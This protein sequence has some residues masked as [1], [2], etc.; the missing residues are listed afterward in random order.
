[1]R[2]LNGRKPNIVLPQEQQA[3]EDENCIHYRDDPSLNKCAIALMDLIT[4]RTAQNQYTTNQVIDE[5]IT[6]HGGGAK[7]TAKKLLEATGYITFDLLQRKVKGWRA[8][9]SCRNLS[10]IPS[11]AVRSPYYHLPGASSYG[12]Y[13]YVF[14]RI[15]DGIYKIGIT[16]NLRTRAP[17]IAAACG[18]HIELYIA[19]QMNDYQQIEVE[20]HE[21]FDHKRTVGEWFELEEKDLDKIKRFFLELEIGGF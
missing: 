1:M 17:G 16:D 15:R 19:I 18:S 9:K 21:C 4:E 5:E 8:V 13:V 14:K 3:V 11:S 20:L 12:G 2:L 6:A 7:S 10:E